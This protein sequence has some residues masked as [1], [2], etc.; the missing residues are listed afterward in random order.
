MPNSRRFH[1]P[2]LPQ[3]VV[4][5]GNNRQDCFLTDEDRS[6]YLLRLAIASRKYA[7]AIHAYA[8]MPNHVHLLATPETGE[9]VGRLMQ[10]VGSGYV[11]TFNARYR[12]S[13]T[14]WDGRYFSSLVGADAYFWNCHR[15][16]ELNPVRAGIVV[17]PDEYHW[18]SFARN[19]LGRPDQVVTP[20]PA[21]LALARCI[22]DV[23]ASYLS[24]FASPLR[25]STLTEIRYRLH[26][27][28]AYGDEA[29][30]SRIEAESP[31][32]PR[33]RGPGRP[34]AEEITISDLIQ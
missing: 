31:R 17:R 20:H 6:E 2:D 22:S 1:V 26:Q 11:R 12:R 10:A 34:A 13:G 8:L 25:E 23:P 24:L 27:E 29:F 5:R 33:C 9:G 16:I 19:A 7:V 4:Q 28:R 14:L 21:Y 15:Y 30:V 3:H 18:S 32:S